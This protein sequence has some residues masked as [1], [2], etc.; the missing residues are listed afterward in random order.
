MDE[1]L[2]HEMF[3]LEG[4]F[5]WFVAKHE[6]IL[7]LVDRYL[8]KIS[9]RVLRACDIGCGCGALL[10]RLRKRLEVVGVD[11]SS[12]ACDY[13]RSRGLTILEGALPDR[14]PLEAESFD[15]VILSDILEHVNRDAES[16]ESAAGLLRPGG[17]LVCTVPAYAWLW[18]PRDELHHHL[19]RY[20][21]RQ[22]RALFAPLPLQSLVL[23]Y[24]NTILFPLMLGQRM[25]TRWFPPDQ[26]Q[27]DLRVPFSP[28]NRLLQWLMSR[29]KHLLPHVRLPWGGSLISVHRKITPASEESDIRGAEPRP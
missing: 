7:S 6:I 15:V 2:Y 19:R 21:F 22:F 5:W 14:I 27:P 1:S 3:Q 20:T 4:R 24:Y 25:W 26:A 13:G 12:L 11:S 28:L 16:A 9:D 10:N 29:E 23:S 17:I 8:P 18:T